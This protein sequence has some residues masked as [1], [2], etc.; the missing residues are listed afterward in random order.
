MAE[1]KHVNSLLVA[2]NKG[3]SHDPGDCMNLSKS[4]GGQARRPWTGGKRH[5][6]PVSLEKRQAILAM[7]VASYRSPR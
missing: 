2:G 5:S 7:V 4:L 3:R 6:F 1:L